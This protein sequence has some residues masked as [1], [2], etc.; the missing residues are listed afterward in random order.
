MKILLLHGAKCTID[1]WNSFDI[2]EE[3][4]KLSYPKGVLANAHNVK[5]IASGLADSVTDAHFDCIIGHSMG[6]LIALDLVVSH[7]IKC[8]KLILIE[9][10]LRPAKQFY[11]NLLLEENKS[12]YLPYLLDMFTEEGTYYS[13]E[14]LNSFQ[15]SFDYT[16]YIYDLDIPIHLIYGDRGFHDYQYRIDDLC[17]TNE[18]IKKIQFHFVRNACHMP[19]LENPS[20]LLEIVNSII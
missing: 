4:I 6:G 1:I 18:S 8:K 3:V 10:N 16:Q 11:R 20:H 5:D 2:N 14:L 19:M 12:R 7:K 15:E 9:T 13:N 17:L